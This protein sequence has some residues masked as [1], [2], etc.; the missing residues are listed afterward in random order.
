MSTDA[1]IGFVFGVLSSL[2]SGVVLFLLQSRR[3]IRQERLKQRRE[4]VRIAR[5]WRTDEKKISLRGFDLAGANLSGKQFPR[6]D[7]EDAS[8]EGARMWA[9]DL[10]DTNLTNASSLSIIN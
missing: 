9:T 1:I 7:L 10:R 5:N 3:D 2:V 4:D 8:F 6:A